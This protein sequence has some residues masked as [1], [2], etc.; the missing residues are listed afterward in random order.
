[1]DRPFDIIVN[2]IIDNIF[3]TIEVGSR[4][5]GD[6]IWNRGMERVTGRLRDKRIIITGAVSNIGKAAV[7]AFVAEG[8]RVVIGDIDVARGEEAAAAFGSAV[9]FVPVH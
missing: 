8:A 4:H 5:D 2:W 3:E 7:E 1:E 6:A 9:R